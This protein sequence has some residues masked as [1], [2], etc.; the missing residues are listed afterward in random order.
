M[1]NHVQ[2]RLIAPTSV[3][4][5]LKSDKSGVHKDVDVKTEVVSDLW[6]I[7]PEEAKEYGLLPAAP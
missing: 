7:G 3:I 2:C 5:S 1:P 4:D 6:R